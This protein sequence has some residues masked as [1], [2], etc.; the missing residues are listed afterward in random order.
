M[1]LSPNIFALRSSLNYSDCPSS[2]NLMQLYDQGTNLIILQVN[3]L[4]EVKEF[5]PFIEGHTPTD[6]LFYEFSVL[7]NLDNN[8][9]YSS[10]LLTNNPVNDFQWSDSTCANSNSDII[11]GHIY[12]AILK[13]RDPNIEYIN[14]DPRV[15]ERDDYVIINIIDI[16]TYDS[17]KD[18]YSQDEFVQNII[19]EYLS[20]VN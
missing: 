8:E 9:L 6:K 11:T 5:D 7:K 19:N 20:L 15:R 1:L 10:R 13:Y 12:I 3:E 16:T 4:I 2:E 14:S 17:T 18:E